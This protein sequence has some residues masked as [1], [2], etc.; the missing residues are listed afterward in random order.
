M[1]E[2]LQRANAAA[3]ATR[4]GTIEIKADRHITQIFEGL[5]DASLS[6]TSV[7]SRLEELK[8]AEGIGHLSQKDRDALDAQRETVARIRARV[9]SIERLLS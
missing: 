5:C 8:A 9:E 2:G 4:A 1:G 6:L 3:R 7:R